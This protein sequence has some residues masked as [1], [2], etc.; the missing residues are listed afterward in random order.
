MSAK[1]TYTFIDIPTQ[2]KL[3]TLPLYGVNFTDL[4][5]QGQG[6]AQAGTFTGSI[7][8]D[9]DFVSGP[10]EVLDIT[11]PEAT[12]VWVDRDDTPI[13]C[14]ILWTRT[15][16]SDGRVLQ[17]NAQT[18]SSYPS[19][20]VWDPDDG[21]ST[22]TITDNPFNVIRYFYQYLATE[23][24]EEYNVGIGL[25]SYHQ[26]GD[27]IGTPD[28]FTTL[29]INKS[30]HKFL[31]EY[32][33]DQLKLGAEYRI[34]P[35]INEAGQRV[36][37]F[38]AGAPGALGVKQDGAEHSNPLQYPGD[39]SKYWLT[40][41]AANA[42]TKMVGVGKADGSDQIVT[43][44]LTDSTGRIGV[45]QVN[46]YDTTDTNLLDTL[47]I[48]DLV[49]AGVQLDRPVYEIGGG[50]ADT[51]WM[52]GDYRRIIIDDPYRFPGPVGG[53]AR[54]VGWG[55]SPGDSDAIEQQTITI[56]NTSGLVALNV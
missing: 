10:Q 36:P 51:S 18:F 1:Y 28:L 27:P 3:G 22:F 50:R 35:I 5:S 29:T 31:N 6:G 21:S 14:G 24:S 12:A 44:Q 49:L 17:L 30:D 53:M 20:V 55:L 56:D 16:Q 40:N 38:Q 19:K 4:L 7:R 26:N 2:Q 42:P 47:T 8:M 32:I 34:L 41:S 54:L 52:L 46:N 11:R 37:M 9:S 25:E 23:A 39:L 13:W 48:N 15:Y 33:N 43:I 45:D